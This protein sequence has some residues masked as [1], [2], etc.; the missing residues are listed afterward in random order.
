MG[1]SLPSILVVDDDAD[2][3][4]ALVDVLSDHGYRA[5][6]VSNGREALETLRRS[7]L[8][9]NLILLDLMMPVMDGTQFRREQLQDP[10][11]RDVPVIVISAGN[12]LDQHAGTVGVADTMRKP[13][14]LERLLATIAR[15]APATH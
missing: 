11:L 2:I 3:R 7:S 12:D 8:L 10:A 13:I 14:D 4:E 15:H 5:S 9:P 1:T 6:A